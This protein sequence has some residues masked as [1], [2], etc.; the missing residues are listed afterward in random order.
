MGRAYQHTTR[1][2]VECIRLAAAEGPAVDGQVGALSSPAL[3]KRQSSLLQE[4]PWASHV[5]AGVAQQRV[6]KQLLAM[7]LCGFKG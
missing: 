3:A 6:I 2:M 4:Q 5:I 7:V 1:A